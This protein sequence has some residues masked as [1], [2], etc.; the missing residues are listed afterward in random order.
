MYELP[1]DQLRGAGLAGL[2]FTRVRL[3]EPLRPGDGLEDLRL[4]VAATS[5]VVRLT[6]TLDG[7]PDLPVDRLCHLIPPVSGTGSAA[8]AYAKEWSSL[9]RYGCFHYRQGPGF[10]IVKDLRPGADARRMRIEDED[11]SGFLRMAVTSHAGELD[12]ATRD[13]LADAETFGLVLRAGDSHLV[14][15]HRIRHF[16]IPAWAA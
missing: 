15:P 3:T 14:L 4:L 11:A 5:H 12:P 8:R 10:V 7:Q 9:H 2:T 16:P 6:W 1:P 13:M